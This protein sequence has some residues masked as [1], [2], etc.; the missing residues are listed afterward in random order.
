[1][2]KRKG[3]IL[4]IVLFLIIGLGTFVFAGGSDE[5]SGDGTIT[6]QPDGGDDNDP[7]NP[8]DPTTE[9]D[10]N[11]TEGED[12]EDTTRPTGGNDNTDGD[13]LV[14]DGEGENN[15]TTPTVDY[16]ALLDELANMVESATSKEDLAEAEQFR[17]DNNITE[18]NVA[19]LDDD[20]ASE[21]YDEVIAILTDNASPVVTPDDLNG[22]FTNKDSVAVEITDTTDVSYTLTIN[23]EEVTDADLANLTE[24]GNYKLTVTDSA[25]NSTTITFT[26]DRTNP[27]LLVNDEEVEN[28]ETIYVN[29]AAKM[30]V[31]ETNLESFTSNGSDRTENVLNGSWTAQKDGAY[32]IV[33]TDK[34]GNETTYTII[35]DKT[36]PVVNNGNLDG[37]YVNHSVSLYIDEKNDYTLTVTRDGNEL[38]GY[39][40][41]MFELSHDG[42]YV[43]TVVDA[44]GNETTVKFTID[45]TDP[46]LYVN[47]E[48]V[49]AGETIYVNEDAKMTVDETNLESFTSNGNDRT[50]S[51]LK[52][53]WT[54][55]NDGPYNIVVT[56][57]AGNETSY[58]I[59]RDTVKI[60]V[61]HL[62][63]LNNSHNDYEVS[64]DVRYK[65]IGNGQDLYV[66]YVLK[67]EFT[68]NPILTIGGKEYEMTCD[69]ASWNDEL[70]KCDA[71]VTIS[72]DMNLVNGEVI[73]FTITG[74]KDIAGN[75]TVVTEKD[76]TVSDK[77][78][79]VVYDNDPAQSIWVYILN[80][81]EDHRT[82]IG[83]NQKLIV[84]INV[85]EELLVNPV[86]TIG[87]YQ[88][89]LTRRAN[90]S[91]YIYS[92]TITIDADEMKLVHDE[93]IAFTISVTDVA[94]N[95]T[96]LDNDNV[97]VHEENGYNQV[98]YDGKAPKYKQ[99]G[100][101]N[102]DHLRNDEDVT[103]AKTGDE[104]RV[105][106]HFDEI[107]DVN[108][109][110][111][112]GES[113]TVYELKLATDYENFAEY[114][115]VADI[116]LTEDMNLSDGA[117]VYTIYGY[118][119]AAG[120]VG[121]TIKSTDE[122]KTYTKFPGVR[123]DNTKPKITVDELN[124]NGYTNNGNVNIAD[125]SEFDVVV[126]IDGEVRH[127]YS[128]TKRADLSWLGDGEYEII[129]TDA[130]GN[131]NTIKFNLDTVAA[132]KHAVYL[133]ANTE[134]VV[135]N[136][137]GKD[138]VVYYVT[139]GDVVTATISVNEILGENPKFV[140]GYNG[141]SY[142]V[143]QDQV[144]F[145]ELDDVEDFKYV[146]S[147]Q[148]TIPE[149]IKTENTELTLTVYNVVDKA[150][151]VTNNG[152]AI[153]ISN[154]NRIFVD[155]TAPEITLYKWFD[156]GNHQ[157]VEPGVHNYCV[158][159]EATDTNLSK[160]TL[161]GNEYNNGEL[162]CGNG[163]Y[164]LIATDKA[165]LTKPINF[166]ID[167]EYGS[168]IINGDEYNTYD[169]DTIHKYNK[170]KSM[171][172]SE[173]GT[174]RLSLNDEVVY[175]GSTEKFNYT[176]VD[177]IYKV[178]LFDKGGN[179]TVVMF[180]LDSVA[181]QVV[182]LRINSSNDDKGYANE[183]HSVGIYL[184]VDEKLASDPIFTIDG[185]EYSKNQGDEDKN[186]YA[187]VTNLPE[188][189]T[190]GEIKFT[191]EV[192]DEFGNGATFTN[193][194]IK[195]DVGYDKVIFD[196]TAPEFDNL[197][198]NTEDFSVSL[199]VTDDAFAYILLKNETT[200]ETIKEERYWTSFSE[201]GTW[202][203]QVFD[204]AGN[205]SEVFTFT[206]KPLVAS[207]I[208]DGQTVNFSSYTELFSAIPDN[209]ETNITINKNS[210]EALV[211][212]EK[213]IVNIDLNNKTVSGSNVITNNGIISEI[214]NGT[215]ES[216][217]YGITNNGTITTINN[218]SINSDNKG[219]YNN[220]TINTVK[221]C[222][223]EARFYP[224]HLVNNSNIALL[225]NNEI[226]GH[227]QSGIYVTN[228][229]SIGEIVSGYYTTY[230]DRPSTGSSIAGF[231]LYIGSSA[232]VE[233]ISGGT[234][235]GNK[236]AVAN[237]GTIESITGGNFEE[238][239]AGNDWAPSTTFLYDGY[240]NSV[241][242]G[243]FFSYG[244]Q[245][246]IFDSRIDFTLTDGY[247]FVQIEDNYYEVQKNN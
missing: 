231:A 32:N 132:K 52:G 131:S 86:I 87:N 25:F 70:Y 159:A 30:T 76:T 151:N 240:V 239:Y 17:K 182:E 68:S 222:E 21:T 229:A 191:I 166:E 180:E 204:K 149:D 138:Y 174:V 79:K 120:N 90:D 69:V 135:E 49:E 16:K 173:E 44:A 201:E 143:P 55:Q 155:T 65:V 169:L 89:E 235:K 71:H 221:D 60:E 80:A 146:Y 209:T 177:G 170:I 168:V 101:L 126:K 164:E 95:T 128:N 125:A 218:V 197:I 186:F 115:Y 93:N 37:A 220:G 41:N 210:N 152:E 111:T 144:I 136:I 176:F 82:I 192:E 14:T 175:F 104:I 59:I 245:N 73:P 215:I 179:P 63:V 109:K 2:D 237:Y 232:K 10:G 154:V 100:V 116:T 188:T 184:T 196:T 195:N 51:I 190:E 105:L 4:A 123:I 121:K 139:N 247:G 48:K 225:E 85:N 212:P 187:V 234:F 145:R 150:G 129:V 203:A 1:M 171:T 112:I 200:G 181:P 134:S 66:E 33:V 233:L 178:E 172:F 91:R 114:T 165:G 147:A 183:T 206:V 35:V 102:V 23:G 242:G 67:E 137:D 199:G 3:I 28:G 202:T 74:V 224:I 228:N 217:N 53:S 167:T 160:I 243:K 7:T 15:P 148:I 83:N 46:V 11:I 108:P 99:L 244:D 106:F 62:Y 140:I 214:S 162:I 193:E 205:G 47:D 246:D 113:K 207:A 230:G 156:D 9:D 38:V 39:Q 161:N 153:G 58:T 189:T 141:G 34:A 8:S 157:V 61:N 27:V 6:P 185:K 119:D 96:T 45:N 26:V 124:D 77:Y 163:Q 81:D 78:G 110:M 194:D 236:A 219:I 238:K 43:V 216:T 84:E 31:D 42:V 122:I 56:D 20:A 227:Y 98:K 19:A 57:K 12:E 36:A 117:L 241:S 133:W 103:V 213:K 92:K 88:V 24:E 72:E 5:G 97:T 211:I 118:A 29:E 94:G 64:D 198:N 13:E 54:A 18:E 50:E 158:L 208:I 223:I 127:E 142:E 75:E 40:D 130:A 226:T 107:L 22:S